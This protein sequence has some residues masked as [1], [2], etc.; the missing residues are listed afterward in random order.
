MY[1]EARESGNGFAFCIL[2]LVVPGGMNGVD[3]ARE[4]LKQYPDAVLL[5]SSGYSEDIVLSNYR[6]YGFR[7]LIPKPYTVDELRIALSDALVLRD[8]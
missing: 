5:V 6:Y 1:A 7:G 4:I 3:A 8:S 2:D